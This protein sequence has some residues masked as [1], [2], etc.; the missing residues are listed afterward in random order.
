MLLNVSE[1]FGLNERFEIALFFCLFG[2]LLNGIEPFV[3]HPQ[4]HVFVATL[5]PNM[6]LA[7]AYHVACD[8]W[9]KAY[10]I[11]KS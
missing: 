2:S 1:R 5:S 8:M 6:F 7:A 9:E 3:K 4:W 11:L 10:A